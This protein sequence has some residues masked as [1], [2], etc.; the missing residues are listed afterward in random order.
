M[1]CKS[2]GRAGASAFEVN[3]GA[4]APA[5]TCGVPSRAATRVLDMLLALGCVR[6]AVMSYN[7][8]GGH[9]IQ[10]T[11]HLVVCCQYTSYCL[12]QRDFNACL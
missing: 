2:I 12:C 5:L 3:V 9:H 10:S 6:G 8:G 1:N 7:V 4:I 11:L